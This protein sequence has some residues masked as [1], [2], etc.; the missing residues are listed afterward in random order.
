MSESKSCAH[1]ENINL[2]FAEAHNKRYFIQ[3]DGVIDNDSKN[4]NLTLL[5]NDYYIKKEKEFFIKGG[6]GATKKIQF[7]GI[8]YD[9]IFNEIK[10]SYK[11]TTGKKWEQRK[12]PRVGKDEIFKE[13]VV[14]TKLTT[15]KE[16]LKLLTK[17]LHK[18]GITVLEIS[19]HNDEGHINENGEKEYN[20]HA[21][22][23]FANCNADGIVKRW[24]KKDYQHLQDIV[25]TSLDMERGERG[26]KA[27]RLSAQQYK[28]VKKNQT[29][30]KSQVKN[31]D[32]L[33]KSTSKQYEEWNDRYIAENSALK[34]QLKQVVNIEAE[35]KQ[36]KTELN[37]TNKSYNNLH[38]KIGE[39]NELFE[40]LGLTG[41]N[42]IATDTK[43][44]KKKLQDKL[45]ENYKKAREELKASGGMATQ[46]DYSNL[47]QEKE[48][49]NEVLKSV[50][51]KHL[52]NKDQL[53]I[54]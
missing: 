4:I 37:E 22:I 6:N 47:K 27:K 3:A 32:Q 50:F 12:G 17:N 5:S 51:N 53:T 7:N 26:S 40:S 44:I 45:E 1:I 20:N 41:I 10:Q 13:M 11:E 25:A 38:N 2:D 54:G 29:E 24:Q 46:K 36:L 43:D 14:N 34:K 35:N 42:V 28:A 33:N 9:K 30:L 15:N 23:I 19:L 16:D 48:H 18:I 49:K 39:L 31:L 21:H 8:D 52:K